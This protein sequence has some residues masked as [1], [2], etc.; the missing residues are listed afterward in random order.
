ML[1]QSLLWAS[2]NR[3]L[4]RRLPRTR[5][6]RRAVRRFMPG[7][8]PEA[9]LEEAE[10]L[11]RQG[12]SSLLTL[13][14]ENVTTEEE[15]DAVARHYLD[16]LAQV[17]ERGLDAQ[18]SVKPTQL[19]LDVGRDV[20]LERLR[21]IAARAAELDNAVW[22]DMEGSQYTDA[23]LEIYRRVRREHDNVGVCLQAYLYRTEED[24]DS[25]LPLHPSIRLVKG[26][27]AEPREIAFPRKAQVDGAF[28]RLARRL[29]E[30]A[31]RAW[32]AFGTH[33]DRMIQGVQAEA[34]ARNL[35]SSAYEFEMLYGIGRE[36][37][38][39][40]AGEGYSMRVLISY[41]SSWFPWYMRRLAERPANLW[42]VAKGLFAR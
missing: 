19:G 40:L 39:G 4:S 5:F 23:T 34:R 33:D 16:L 41:G 20:A 3:W 28:L 15:A 29:L 2:R 37:Q 42:F 8:E 7:E 22:V 1:R 13:L 11:R 35:P 14:G 27:Y 18:L 38:L 9:A 17:R 21:A 31:G 26:A 32:P 30:D 36:R 24:L 12:L 25:L 10:R 6:I